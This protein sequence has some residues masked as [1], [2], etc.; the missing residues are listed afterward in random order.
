MANRKSTDY[1]MPSSEA[2]SARLEQQ[3]ELYGGVE[4][5]EPFLDDRPGSVL[6]VGCGTGFF[7]RHAASELPDSRVVGLDMDESRLAFA[8][9]AAA[10]LA[11]LSFEHGQVGEMLFD[12]GA[13]ELVFSRFVMVHAS[14]PTA[15][16]EEMRRVTATGG[17]VVNYDMVHE[18]VWFSPH[19]PAFA[20]VMGEVI[21]TMR[22]RGMEPNQGLHLGP[23]MLGVGFTDVEV[24][25]RPHH[26][27]ASDPRFDVYRR[28]WIATISE[29]E[30]ILG[31][32][33]DRELIDRALAELEDTGPHQSLL[34][35]TVIA[36][37]RN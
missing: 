13:F 27:P 30:S 23:A 3:A 37:G 36:S 17:R 16:L 18:G 2:E 33:F 8:R 15:V 28:N 14:D 24:R 7:A 6:D 5:L 20:A 11:N 1:I 4:F 25:V 31:A 21:E 29:I 22:E 35:L 12:D 19:K 32:G 26:F 34:E 10:G 9:E